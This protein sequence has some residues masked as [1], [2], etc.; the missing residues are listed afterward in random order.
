MGNWKHCELS[1]LGLKLARLRFEHLSSGICQHLAPCRCTLRP[2]FGPQTCRRELC[3]TPCQALSK[4]TAP[5]TTSLVASLPSQQCFCTTS[6]ASRRALKGTD[7]RPIPRVFCENLWFPCE[8]VCG[9]LRLSRALR[10]LELPGEGANVQR[11]SRGL[12]GISVV[13]AWS[14]TSG[15]SP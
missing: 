3:R 8:E 12:L 7:P 6:S 9:F 4:E 1:G 14:I 5:S 10:V 13:L 2:P 15:P 11:I